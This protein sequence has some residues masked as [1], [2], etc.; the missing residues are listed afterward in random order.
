MSS[1]NN[2]LVTHVKVCL[3]IENSCRA[4]V[5]ARHLWAL[6]MCTES[7]GFIL[8]IILHL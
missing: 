6:I 2:N 5:H 3:L 4:G 1:M 7:V 8:R